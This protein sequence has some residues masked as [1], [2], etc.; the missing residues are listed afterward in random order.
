MITALVARLVATLLNAFG[1]LF[2]MVFVN[3]T[4]EPVARVWVD[5]DTILILVLEDIALVPVTDS[6][7][8]AE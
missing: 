6:T 7:L 4:V 3:P 2:T 1:L 8:E 5:P